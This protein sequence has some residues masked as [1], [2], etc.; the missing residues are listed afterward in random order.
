MDGWL[1]DDLMDKWVGGEVSGRWIDGRLD[2][3]ADHCMHG[4]VPSLEE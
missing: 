2:S 4:Y 3:W 1:I